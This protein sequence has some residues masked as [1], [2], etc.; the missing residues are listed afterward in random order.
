MIDEKLNLIFRVVFDI[1]EDIDITSIKRITE[2]RWDSMANV[3]LISALE[4]EFNISLNSS[5][6]ERLTS[7][8]GTKILIEEKYK[9]E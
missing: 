6:A 4:S 1:E 7:Y 5:D 8:A 9:N 3:T 2:E